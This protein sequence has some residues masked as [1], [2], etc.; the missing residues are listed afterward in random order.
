MKERNLIL[1]ALS[2]L[3]L[4]PPLVWLILWERPEGVA[5]VVIVASAI[6]LSELYTITLSGDPLPMRLLGVA[7]GAALSAVI[8][9]VQQPGVLMLALVAIT[10][11]LIIVRL[12]SYGELSRA[13]ANTALTLFGHLYVVLLLTCLPLLKRLDHGGGWVILVL[14]ITWFSDTGAYFA[15]RALGRHKLYPSISPNKSVEGAIGGLIAAFGA[16]VL[17]RSWYLPMLSW[18][19]AA[20]ISVPGSA[21]G[22]LGDLVESMIKRGYDVKDS[23]R[24]IPGHGGLLDRI[25][26]LLF[27]SPYVYFYVLYAIG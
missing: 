20:L 27:V 25:D 2:A 24:I 26:A 9:W 13:T 18:R 10:L 15:G 22:Q 12:F 21:L 3:V 17:A 1:R 7:C 16:A 11:L 6:A 8:F 14:T 4:A 19:D 23:G 5:A